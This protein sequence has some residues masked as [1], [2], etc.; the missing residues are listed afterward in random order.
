MLNKLKVRS[1]KKKSLRDYKDGFNTSH[2]EALFDVDEQ[3]AK[4]NLQTTR[5]LFSTTIRKDVLNSSQISNENKIIYLNSLKCSSMRLMNKTL[6]V[7]LQI[8]N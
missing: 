3:T 6:A 8:S 1:N 5:R 4:F 7:R 2:F